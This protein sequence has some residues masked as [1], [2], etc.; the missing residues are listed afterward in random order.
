MIEQGRT[1]LH[2][3]NA[4]RD[5]LVGGAKDLPAL[6]ANVTAAVAAIHAYASDA[7]TA[8][9]SA[10]IATSAAQAQLQQVDL[11][12][13]AATVSA[14]ND[15]F[16]R[17]VFDS[18]LRFGSS[19]DEEAYRQREAERDRYV[20]QQLAA[21]TPEGNLNAGG[22]E[23]GQLMDA[24]AHGADKSPALASER[25]KLIETLGRQR[26]AV[27]AAGGSTKE[28]DE[29]VD[30]EARRYFRSKG[31]SDEEIDKRLAVA[32]S[33]LDAVSAFMDGKTAAPAKVSMAA[34]QLGGDNQQSASLDDAMKAFRAAGVIAAPAS[35]DQSNPTVPVIAQNTVAK[36]KTPQGLG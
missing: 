2:Q 5:Q 14:A 15:L 16:E 17:K 30:Q 32:G 1:Q 25:E 34:P 10:S 22:A 11:A 35:L 18:Y 27:H 3:L 6:R 9:S 21:H 28:F 8:A 36:A 20:H 4:L 23:L 31:L 24:G 29:V 7:R 26:E 13:R 12:T 19:G 33:P